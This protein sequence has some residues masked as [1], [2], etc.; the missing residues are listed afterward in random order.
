TEAGFQSRY[1]AEL[2]NNLGNLVNRTLNMINKYR[3]GIV[4]A[5]AHDLAPE[6]EKFI[7]ETRQ[8][9]EAHRIQDA[10]V[11]TWNL[12][13]R[14]NQFVDQTAPFKLAKDPAQAGRL[15]EV[16]Y[17]LAEV[18]RILTVLIA[19]VLSET[20]RKILEQLALTDQPA[21][22]NLKW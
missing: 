19:P 3:G 9:L 16:L 14:A 4:P 12:A 18:C 20:S 10:L 1:S 2:A 6:A 7:T 11:S 22:P 17:S 5:V 21:I 8:H 15:D 13:T